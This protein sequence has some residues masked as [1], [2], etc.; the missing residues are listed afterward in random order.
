LTDA[1]I[2]SSLFLSLESQQREAKRERAKK[3]QGKGKEA[4]EEEDV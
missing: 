3:R 4:A 1:T 2:A